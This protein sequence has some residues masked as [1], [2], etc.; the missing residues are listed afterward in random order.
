MEIKTI[1]E[2]LNRVL[3]KTNFEEHNNKQYYKVSRED[4][5][6]LCIKFIKLIERIED[7]RNYWKTKTM[8]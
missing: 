5:I 2:E 7:G 1:K 3:I 8:C 6:R 4:L